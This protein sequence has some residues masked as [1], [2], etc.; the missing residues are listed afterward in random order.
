MESRCFFGSVRRPCDRRSRPA[1]AL[2]GM[3]V[4]VVALLLALPSRAPA[5]SIAEHTGGMEGQDGF[6]TLHWDDVDGTLF[7][8]IER[9][10][11][12][13]LYLRSLAT[14]VGSNRLGLDRGMIGG[15][16]IGRF[17]RVGPKVHFVLQNP[18][19]RAVTDR[20]EALAR[21][22][23]ES[24]PTST[25][26]SW[27]IVAQEDG[28]VLVDATDYFLQDAMAVAAR[29]QAAGQGS[30]RVDADRS[31]IHMPRTKAFPDNT[32]VEAALTFAGDRPGGEIRQHTPDGRSLTL[33]QH[34]SF[35]RLPDDGY[36][37]RAFDPRIGLFNVSFFDYGK[38]FDEEYVTRY[39][40]RHRLQKADPDA[41]MSEAVEPIVYYMDPAI[42]E[43][44]R[45]AFKDGGAWWNEVFEAAGFID[46]FQIR[47]MPADMDQ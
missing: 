43:P 41:P 46:G 25:V 30:F 3:W 7:L 6:V 31:R 44:Y 18:S 35:V 23:E 26:A 29:L 33:R 4:G 15:E 9:L 2:P 13:F 45:S 21:S 39:A 36:R 22:V 38:S 8:E 47:D 37:P 34:H 28:T 12:D 1:A 5:Q 10:G 17:E 42:P 20:T 14:G 32:E 16:Y 19:F 11:E 24:F 27:E 40:V